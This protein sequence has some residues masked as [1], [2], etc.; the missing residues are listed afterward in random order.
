MSYME[1]KS[2]P[3]GEG[4]NLICFLHYALRCSQKA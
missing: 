1:R 4:L 2:L 3:L